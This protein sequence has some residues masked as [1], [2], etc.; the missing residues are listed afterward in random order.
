MGRLVAFLKEE[1]LY[2]DAHILFIT[3]HGGIGNGHGGVS[4]EEMIVPWVVSGPG[5]KEGFTISEPNN[6]V[7][8]AATVLRLFGVEQPLCWTGEVPESIFL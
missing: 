3:D 5:I 4:T 8:T 2:D 7:N 6:T 1:G